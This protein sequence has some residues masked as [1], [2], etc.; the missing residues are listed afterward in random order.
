[1]LF[2]DRNVCQRPGMESSSNMYLTGHEGHQFTGVV[3]QT[4]DRYSHCRRSLSLDQCEVS[5][6]RRSLTALLDSGRCQISH[7]DLCNMSQFVVSEPWLLSN[8]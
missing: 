6:R 3:L 2:L 7:G 1:M 4:L 8:D 5:S